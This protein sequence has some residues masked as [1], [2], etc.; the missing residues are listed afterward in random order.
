MDNFDTASKIVYRNLL[1]WLRTNITYDQYRK[2]S[3]FLFSYVSNVAFGQHCLRS[4]MLHQIA[5]TIRASHTPIHE[6]TVHTPQKL[7]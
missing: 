4:I 2:H 1:Y 7:L 5:T 3:I 6:L